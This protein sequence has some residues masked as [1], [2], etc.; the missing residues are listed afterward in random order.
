MQAEPNRVGAAR[1]PRLRAVVG[2]LDGKALRLV[3]RDAGGHGRQVEARRPDLR[4]ADAVRGGRAGAA[5]RDVAGGDGEG[6][7]SSAGKIVDRGTG[8]R[9]GR[10]CG[11]ATRRRGHRVA[12]DRA[13]AVIGR[14]R[15]A[16]RGAVVAEGRRRHSGGSAGH[17]VLRHA[18]QPEVAGVGRP[19]VGARSA[20]PTPRVDGGPGAGDVRAEVEV[21][22][23]T[24]PGVAALP[25]HLAPAH[26]GALGHVE[27][28]QVRVAGAEA[29]GM[30]DDD[31]LAEAGVDRIDA[32]Q[33]RD[34]VGG[35]VDVL[36]IHAIVEA[37]V[38]VVIEVVAAAGRPGVAQSEGGV[39]AVGLPADG[40]VEAADPAVGGVVRIAVIEDRGDGVPTDVGERQEGIGASRRGRN[41][42]LARHA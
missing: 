1:G 8:R 22:A 10:G 37:V 14:C 21:G 26:I 35:R 32:D 19:G 42:G 17:R 28:R 36:V 11:D 5:A 25:N 3:H 38:A 39:D 34:A 16:H 9:A 12:G 4:D 30:I 40:A 7:G 29:V 33:A 27:R 18:G 13:A 6:V 24:A 23:A 15:P 2:H 41:P 20:P 31:R